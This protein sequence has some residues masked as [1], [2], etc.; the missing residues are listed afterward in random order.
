M[1]RRR[2]VSDEGQDVYDALSREAG[3][4]RR[5]AGRTQGWLAAEIETDQQ[6][7]SDYERGR[8]RIPLHVVGKIER[9]LN[10]GKGELLLRAGLVSREAVPAETSTESAIRQDPA[11]DDVAREVM[12]HVYDFAR[13]DVADGRPWAS[14]G[15]EPAPGRLT[16]EDM[17]AMSNRQLRD[18]LTAAQRHQPRDEGEPGQQEAG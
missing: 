14:G 7:L 10:L 6:T 17:A 18:A 3:R 11:L 16:H 8:T 12:L 1:P 13:R 4:A 9:A 15:A 5:A 2:G